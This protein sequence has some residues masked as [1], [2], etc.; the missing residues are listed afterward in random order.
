[1]NGSAKTI[2]VFSALFILFACNNKKEVSP[3][4]DILTRQPFAPLTDSIA[5]DPQKDELWFRRAVLLNKD[6]HPGPALA[7][8]RQ[9]WALKKDE[10][11]AFGISTLLLDKKPDSARIFLNDALKELPGNFL[12]QLTLARAHDAQGFTDAAL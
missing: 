10:R 4:D 1:M 6:N 11:Y 8:F 2:T 12:L 7:D 3:Y 9:A 5:K